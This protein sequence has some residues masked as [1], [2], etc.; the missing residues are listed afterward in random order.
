ML[1]SVLL[2]RDT[3]PPL[4]VGLLGDWGSGK[5][6]LM[7]LMQER[8]DEIAALRRAGRP[9]AA[10]F[11]G[12]VRQIRF[13]A[14]HYVDTSLWASLA[15]ALFD[16]LAKDGKAD[17]DSMGLTD[18]D[19]VRG[20]AAAARS[21]RECL[22]SEVRELEE[23]VDRV[24]TIARFEA[25]AAMRAVRDDPDLVAK[26][27]AVADPHT[28]SDEQAE[29]VAA[30]L[31]SLAG[32]GQLTFAGVRLFRDEI[33]HRRRWTAGL[34]AV[35]VA[36]GACAVYLVSDW[37]VAAKAGT[38]LAAAAVVLA[39]AV[40][41]VVQVLLLA[42]QAREARELPLLERRRRLA[43]ARQAEEH[44]SHAVV[45]HERAREALRHKGA[46]LRDWVRER[47][48][49][50]DYAQ[51]LGV[52]AKIRRDLEELVGL[53]EEAADGP[54]DAVGSVT[55]L[56]A[57]P[58][59]PV[60]RIILYIDDLDRCPYDKVVEVLQAVHLLLAFKLFVVVV[61]VDSRWLRESLHEHYGALLEE[62]DAYLEKIFQIPFSV[63]PM[64]HEVYAHLIH[65]LTAQRGTEDSNLSQ[66]LI[67]DGAAVAGGTESSAIGATAHLVHDGESDEKPSGTYPQEY[68]P[69]PQ[70][71]VITDAERVL[72]GHL[73]GIVPNPRSAKRLV[74]IYRMLRVSVPTEELD[75]FSPD[76]GAEYEAVVLLLGI[77]VGLPSITNAVYE[78]IMSAE[79][80]DDVW[81]VI[82]SASEYDVEARDLVCGLRAHMSIGTV[83]PYRRWVPRVARFS[84][85][86][87]RLYLTDRA[88]GTRTADVSRD[89]PPDVAP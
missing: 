3:A 29:R 17:A 39:P 74:N 86:T 57:E 12:E 5:S 46:L 36:G 2:A 50:P 1:V 47:A 10:P 49:S 82:A 51:E 87:G 56:G 44:A 24:A 55:T 71:L 40:R 60:E 77:L 32:V 21:I 42:R 64:A 18:L 80:A 9:E 45:Q 79:P 53:I 35:I 62:P 41:G 26:L 19:A 13:N 54:G 34:A 69:T 20:E 73:H 6:F 84:F 48:L 89:R 27:R 85:H 68:L 52:I 88:S 78:A 66:H 22:E 14:W 72:L 70:A 43:E 25:V 75:A 61:G 28:R 63:R 76:G 7:A 38:F 81:R 58:V 83:A 65:E 16:G 59:A 31:S 15:A 33:W 23:S 67:A 11:C 37:S 4:A 8:V 30:T